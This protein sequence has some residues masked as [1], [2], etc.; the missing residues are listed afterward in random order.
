MNERME[1]LMKET[2]RRAVIGVVST[3]VAALAVASPASAGVLVQTTTS[4]D[5]QALSKPFAPWLDPMSYTL[6]PGGSMEGGAAGWK[7]S[8][9]AHVVA[10]NE[11]WQVNNSGD[12]AS[13]RLPAGSSAVSAPICVGL[14]HPTLRLFAR[15]NSGLLSALA[16]SVRV[17][18]QAGG[19]LELPFGVVAAGG[20]WTPT[21]PM[22][23]VANALPLLP[24]QYTPVS[25]RFTPLLGGDWQIDDVYVDPYRAR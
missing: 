21:L 1:V 13:L 14:T 8:G 16:V 25:F 20:R 9:G 4:C 6:V 7:L 19:T 5:G 11:P 10:G 17:P 22:L 18:L 23:F 2:W 12:S 3:M 15:K 24:G